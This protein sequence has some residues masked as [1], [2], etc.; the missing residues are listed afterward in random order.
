MEQNNCDLER[1]SRP[2]TY[3][4]LAENVSRDIDNINYR[5]PDKN[6]GAASAIAATAPFNLFNSEVFFEDNHRV[7]G[8][9]EAVIVHIGNKRILA[10]FKTNEVL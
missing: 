4:F 7:F 5:C 8:I 6:S 1:I 10:I 9:D 2:K 3:E